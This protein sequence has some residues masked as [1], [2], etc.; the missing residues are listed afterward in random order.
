LLRS[1]R[2]LARLAGIALILARYD[3][4]FPFYGVR[5]IGPYLRLACAIVRRRRGISA[6]R[7]GQRLAV[8]FNELGPSFI[9]LGQLLSTRSDLLGDAV[10]ADLAALQDR[11]PPFPGSEARTLIEAEFG[12]PLDTLFTAF[13]E[14]AIAAASI[15]QVHFARTVD[16]RDVAVKVLRPGIAAAFARDLDLLRWLAAWLERLQPALRRLKP[17]EVVRTLADV[18]RF[19]M[20]LRFE[21]AAAS[22]LAENFA[23]DPGFRVPLVDWPRTGR[24]VLTLERIS[25]VRVDDRDAILAAGHAIDALLAKAASAFFNQVFRDGFFHA[26]LHPG[27]MFVAEDGALVVVDF[28]IMGRLDRD[29]RYY[30]ADMLLGFLSGDYQRVAEVHFAAGYVP[31]EQ[32]VAAFTQACRSI[33]EPILGRPLQEI[34]IGRLLAQLFGITEQFGMETQP[35]LLLLQ[36]TIVLVEGV[37]RRLDPD[38][39][40][41]TLARPLLEA[42]MRDNRGPEARLR[43]GLE[44]A[45]EMVGRLPRLVNNLDALV[46]DMARDG[47]VLHAETIAAH[48]AAQAKRAYLAVIPLWIAAAALVAI[49]LALTLGR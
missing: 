3:A 44:T 31:S 35:Q 26:D 23:G 49:A 20:D 24:V 15:A 4:L 14:T 13:D 41:W 11:L 5:S 45:I 17:V 37:G 16:G 47:V 30:L 42:W 12:R 9:K 27:N 21:A 18:V 1:V 40:I 22:E 2:C 29:T 28:G 48:A 7:A 10:A 36:K 38:I 34:S 32:S 25:G 39:N 6:L 33:G 8:A 19:E 43:Q 46:G